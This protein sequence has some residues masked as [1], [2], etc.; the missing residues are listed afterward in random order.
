MGKGVM[1]ERIINE[2]W[3]DFD[4]S[5]TPHRHQR[6]C[7]VGI[8]IAQ[9]ESRAFNCDIALYMNRILQGS[10]RTGPAFLHGSKFS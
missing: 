3:K 2:G 9:D 7:S 5:I 10:T 4:Y 6:N 1:T 8:G